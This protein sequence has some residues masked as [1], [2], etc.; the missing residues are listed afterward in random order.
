MKRSILIVSFS[1]LVVLASIFIISRKIYQNEV[2]YQKNVLFKQID[3]CA[4]DIEYVLARFESDINFILFSD[5]ISELFSHSPEKSETLRKLELFYSSYG[6]LIKNID[7]YDNN[8]NGFNLFRDKK[9]ISDNY[10]AQR[11]RILFDKEQVKSDGDE[12]HY[13]IPVFRDN[14]IYGNMVVTINL[15]EYILKELNR[16]YL[17]DIN[18]Q[19]A[20]D[21]E[22][23][24]YKTNFPGKQIII[25][26]VDELLRKVDEYQTNV[27]LKHKVS[28]DSLSADLITA[29]GSI[30][31]LDHKFGLA[32][33]HNNSYFLRQI[34]LRSLTL[35]IISLTIFIFTLVYLFMR[36]A[37][38]EK[39]KKAYKKEADLLKNLLLNLP[40]G[41]LISDSNN[42]IKYINQ[43]ATEMF[44][45][46]PDE[47]KTGNAVTEKFLQSNRFQIE[48]SK[49]SAYDSNQFILYQKE[50]NE[51]I[52]YRKACAYISEDIEYTLNAFI[53]ITSIEKSRK[54]EAASNTAKSEFL[55]KMSHEI[56][57]PMNGI[58]GM[59]EALNQENLTKEQKEYIDIIKKSADL[60]LNLIDDILDYSK[61][62][63]GKMP[64]E[65]IPFRIS[66]EVKLALDL[67]KAIIEEKG[68][69]LTMNIS[70]E[71]TDDVIGD[72]FRLRQVLSNLISNAIKFTHEGEIQVLVKLDEKYNGNLTLLFEI[73]DTGVGIPKERLESIFSSFTQADYSTSR[74]YG[75][76]GLGTT[77]SKQLVDL[78]HGEIW[79][80]SPSGISRNKKY[81][82]TKFCFTIEVF[83]NEELIKEL[84]FSDIKNFSD[85]NAFIIAQNIPSKKRLEN[86]LKHLEINADSLLLKENSEPVKSII[87]QLKTKD[88]QVIFIINDSNLDGL[89]IG[90]Q[91]V[92][93]KIADNYRIFMISSKHKQENYVQ[94]KLNRI[95]YYLLEPVELNIFKK[96]FLKW[97]PNA[98]ASLEKKGSVLQ[99]NLNILV[100]E[101]NLINQKVAETIF[102]N[103]GYNIDIAL[104]GTD[105]V[106]MVKK[107]SYDIIFMDLQMPEKDGVESTVEIRGLGFQMPIVAMTA[108][109]SN[110]SREQALHSGMNDYITK[111][112]K[113]DAVRNILQKWFS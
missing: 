46:K 56:R 45:L 9:F 1:I 43:I 31:L 49:P 28:G 105:V 88:Y 72:P 96:Y 2:I 40:I 13:Y 50:G 82:G 42:Q 84:N 11:Q 110:L 83:S 47:E 20:F 16:F 32:F 78:M 94:S 74:K 64:L 7:I 18:F 34:F 35:S 5:D 41:V 101:D 30:D 55:A 65:E 14:V 95:D 99:K 57:T 36:F 111:P 33:S 37:D 29:C 24:S 70:D 98:Q 92:Q 39:K 104:N 108:T 54:Y 6:T 4:G 81:P 48:K 112:V 66:E 17:E 113:T 52:L 59:T 12:Y 79:V 23:G 71:V 93:A 77:I 58:I 25:G 76:S 53:D 97:F 8:K 38:S 19:W 107:K 102:R 44:S 75:G 22:S 62:E 21:L 69:N 87:D 27:I 91:L 67:F 86:F 26:K 60:L 109:T 90:R 103:L 100:A 61:I 89:W 80:E 3:L 10:V 73:S 63:A 51:L 85:I 15:P 106:E 68:L